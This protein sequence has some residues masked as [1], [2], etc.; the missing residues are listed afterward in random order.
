MASRMTE[1]G[2]RYAVCNLRAKRSEIAGEITQLELQ[3]A[4]R[5]RDLAKVDDILR[6]LAPA[7]DPAQIA[8]KKAIKYL[9]IFR[10]GVGR[11]IVGVLRAENRPM[12]NLE[13]TRIIFER[14]GFGPELWTPIRRRTQTNLFYLEKMGRVAKDGRGTAA[15][16]ALSDPNQCRTE[17]VSLRTPLQKTG[18]EAA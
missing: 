14:G 16:W 11:L 17:A 4:Y 12:G 9:N 8:P 1:V 13:I 2:F 6:V 7:S 10:Q 5:R 3:V 18:R 15:Q